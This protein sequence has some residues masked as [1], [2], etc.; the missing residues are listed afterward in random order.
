MKII[1]LSLTVGFLALTA[2]GCSSSLPSEE[3]AS[4]RVDSTQ[5]QKGSHTNIITQD[6]L[7]T[8]IS[9]PS[10]TNQQKQQLSVFKNSYDNDIN[11]VIKTRIAQ[12]NPHTFSLLKK[13]RTLAFQVDSDRVY[14]AKTK[15]VHQKQAPDGTYLFWKGIL[16]N[17]KGIGSVNL[18]YSKR[19]ILSGSVG[20]LEKKGHGGTGN[21]ILSLGDG[22]EA[23]LWVY[24]ENVRTYDIVKTENHTM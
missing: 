1:K 21:K 5:P 7:F 24:S 16:Q 18:V 10:L 17:R 20:I 8:I 15:R 23:I 22:L 14:V 6:T 11:K 3:P 19:R 2:W 4:S 12:L 13:A 9:N